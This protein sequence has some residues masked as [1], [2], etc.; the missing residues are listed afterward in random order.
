MTRERRSLWGSIST[1]KKV[2][3]ISLKAALIY[4]WAIPHFD[5]EG[6][7][8]GEPREIK[9]KIV[10]YRDEISIEDVKNTI[11]ELSINKL[12]KVFHK[13][14]TV[15]IYDPVF[16]SRQSF[17]GLH[18]IPSKIKPLV[19]DVPETVFSIINNSV[20]VHGGPCISKVKLSEVKL[21]EVKRSEVPQN[22][23]SL[24]LNQNQKPSKAKDQV[25]EFKAGRLKI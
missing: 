10:P 4:T 8:D 6:F 21:S 17:A 2:N 25:A 3:Q 1:S 14:S 11:I 13:N 23:I 9:R 16:N 7:Q 5:D 12:W 19:V 18:K 24:S 22:P 20:Q 15:F